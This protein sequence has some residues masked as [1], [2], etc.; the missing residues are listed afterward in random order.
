[1]IQQT[2]IP[3]NDKAQ[4][5]P[6]F[7]VPFHHAWPLEGQVWSSRWTVFRQMTNVFFQWQV[8][9]CC[10]ITEEWSR[11][12]ERPGKHAGG[13]LSQLGG[14]NGFHLF[15]NF[16]FL[17][18]KMQVKYLWYRVIVRFKGDNKSKKKLNIMPE[19][20]II[21][22]FYSFNHVSLNT[23]N[24]KSITRFNDKIQEVV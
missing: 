10:T 1:M 19:K 21:I 2:E 9:S 23:N 12:R 11:S 17:T 5:S 6:V 15:L 20:R 14:G 4:Q 22:H 24:N 8:H 16:S 18:C 7:L 3:R 13:I